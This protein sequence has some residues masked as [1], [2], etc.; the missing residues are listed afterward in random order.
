MF[1]GVYSDAVEKASLEARRQGYCVTEQA[2]ADGSIKLTVEV[3]G[4]A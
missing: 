4:A 2:L 3:G 1:F